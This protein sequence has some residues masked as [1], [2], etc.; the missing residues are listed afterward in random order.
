M[1]L[2]QLGAFIK[3][4]FLIELSYE[5]HFVLLWLNI[6]GSIA[7]IY[8]VAKLFGGKVSLYLGEYGGQY[9]LSLLSV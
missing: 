4:D 9:F 1:F 6:F 7:I 8:F 5:L 3:R 2:R